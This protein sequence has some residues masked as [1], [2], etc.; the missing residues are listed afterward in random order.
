MTTSSLFLC[1]KMMQ[2]NIHEAK[3]HF[4]KLIT[5]ALQGEEIIIAK[6]GKPLVVLTP[7]KKKRT[8]R[9][10]GQLRG[11]IKI[12]KNFD[13]PLPGDLLAQFYDK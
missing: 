12:S 1:G 6:D 2:F 13:A 7:Y 11:M 10:G 9:K 3:T 8:K 5:Q 4:S